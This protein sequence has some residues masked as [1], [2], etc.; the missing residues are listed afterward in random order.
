MTVREDLESNA[1]QLLTDVGM[2]SPISAF[3]LAYYCGLD[4][5]ATSR[6]GRQRGFA[7]YYDSPVEH[8]REWQVAIGIAHWRLAR[9][10]APRVDAD[11]DY[12]A[13]AL[14]LPRADFVHDARSKRMYILVLQR[15]RYASYENIKLRWVDLYEEIMRLQVVGN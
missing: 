4:V 6:I 12:L 14:M 9:I 1:L 13:R 5:A 11:V 3:T 10:G 15:H 8:E 2:T 7:L